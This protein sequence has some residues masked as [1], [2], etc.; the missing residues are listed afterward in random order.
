MNVKLCANIITQYIYI[1]VTPL[2]LHGNAL[3]IE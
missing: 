3:T 1:L 2:M